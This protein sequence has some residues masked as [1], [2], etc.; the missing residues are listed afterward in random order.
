MSTQPGAGFVPE[1]S[2][3]DRLRKARMLTGMTTRDF[4]AKIGV[5]QKTLTDA[6]GDRRQ[7]VRKPIIAAYSLATGVDAEWLETGKSPTG[8][9]P[10]GGLVDL[11]ARR[12]SKP[13]P[14]DPNVG[15]QPRA[16]PLPTI[17]GGVGDESPWAA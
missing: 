3:G 2:R 7:T 5:S 17:A 12:Y 4:A 6:E 13:Q 16:I 15:G 8:P 10:D 11:R 1:W 14:S 9:G